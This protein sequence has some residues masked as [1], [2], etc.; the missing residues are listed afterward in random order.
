[1]SAPT[2][3]AVP[4]SWAGI[5]Q[6]LMSSGAW[7]FSGKVVGALAV[8]GA[9]AMLSRTLAPEQFGAYFLALSMATI[10]ATVFQLGL[11]QAVIRLVGQAL[12]EGREGEAR[13]R[14]GQVFAWGGAAL[15]IGCGIVYA[16]F[17]KWVAKDLLESS[18]V[19]GVTGLIALLLL[20]HGFQILTAESHRA[21]SDIRMA[22]LSEGVLAR[23]GFLLLL[24]MAWLS[25]VRIGLAS[26]LMLFLIASLTGVV[27]GFI[28]LKRRMATLGPSIQKDGRD[29]VT[30]AWPLWL[31]SIITMLLNQF[32]VWILGLLRP[33]ED[34]AL[35][36]AALRLVTFV[37]MPLLLANAIVPPLIAQLSGSNHR[38]SLERALRIT[39]TIAGVPALVLLIGFVFV[40]ETILRVVYGDYYGEG[41]VV[42]AILS[43]GRIVYVWTGSCGLALMLSGH[44]R[45]MLG[46]TLFSGL[47]AL[48]LSLLL[49]DRYGLPGVAVGAASGIAL[50]NSLALLAARRY[51]GVWAHMDPF[52]FLR[53]A[54]T[55]RAA[56]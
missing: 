51:V 6:R 1:M 20:V 39:A 25:G 36:G 16:G 19:L 31:L 4:V 48:G 47:V 46:I 26:A 44:Q 2:D 54:R 42:L 12:S 13:F 49:V 30:T 55:S 17:G 9:N 27:V 56:K 40:G 5:R 7:A 53:Y 33:D 45:L 15:L 37:A 21:L 22:T 41:A 35:Y 28:A 29:L 50:Q 14:I 23:V 43:L 11:H 3:H 18:L 24:A 52:L 32:D 8:L 34:V 38:D 10:L